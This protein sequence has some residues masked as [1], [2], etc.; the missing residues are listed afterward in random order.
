MT[1]EV[2]YSCEHCQLLRVKVQVPARCTEDV[3]TWLE[4]VAVRAVAADHLRRSPHCL[5]TQLSE[6][7]VPITG[8]AK[9]GGPA[10]N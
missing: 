10:L 1:I 9:I 5:S 2:M 4:Q 6:L 8:A 7:F 3:V